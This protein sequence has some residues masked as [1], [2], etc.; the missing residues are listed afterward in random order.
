MDFYVAAIFHDIAKGRGGDHSVLGAKDVRVFCKQHSIGG[1]DLKL[2]EFIVA[3]HLLMSHVA[4]KQDTTDPDVV[5]NFTK[6]VGNERYLT[7][8]YLLRWPTSAAPHPKFGTV[9]KP[10][11]LRIYSISVCVFWV[12]KR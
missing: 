6:R 11:C 8:L 1:E 12:I 10:N 3:N 5:A 2:I 9:G 4:Q 7:A